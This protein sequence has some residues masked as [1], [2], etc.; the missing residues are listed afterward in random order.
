MIVKIKIPGLLFIAALTVVVLSL[1]V[2][3]GFPGKELIL[4]FSTKTFFSG[5]IYR[6]FT[7]PFTHIGLPHIVENMLALFVLT[8]LAF[9]VGLKGTQFVIAFIGASWLVA[10]GEAPFFPALLIA[11]ASVGI[12]AISG[13]V[14]AKGSKFIPRILL[15][16]ILLSPLLLKDGLSILQN[17]EYNLSSNSSL[18]F[19]LS[20]FIIGAIF[21]LLLSLTK[22]DKPVLHRPTTPNSGENPTYKM[23]R[24]RKPKTILQN[25]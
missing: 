9:E 22:E 14:G 8:I 13:F 18:L 25:N 12:M 17:G 15:L 11:G 24:L 23:P 19:H 10:F 6:L 3:F 7:F 4:A 2:F 16:P 20:G 5:E 1:I 21:F